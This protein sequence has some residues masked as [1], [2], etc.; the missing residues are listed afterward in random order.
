M[1][2]AI[3]IVETFNFRRQTRLLDWINDF[4]MWLVIVNHED[5]NFKFEIG[6]QM[7]NYQEIRLKFFFS[8]SWKNSHK[9]L[10]K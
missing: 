9:E 6:V 10:N 1:H 2:G 7:Q 3:Y 4:L 8:F 5:S